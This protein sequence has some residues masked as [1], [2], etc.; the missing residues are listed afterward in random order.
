MKSYSI[1]FIVDTDNA[2][3]DRIFHQKGMA[4]NLDDVITQTYILYKQA[5]QYIWKNMESAIFMDIRP[6]TMFS[7]E[8]ML[9]NSCIK[10]ETVLQ[11]FFQ[12]RKEHWL[13]SVRHYERN[14][15]AL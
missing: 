11:L 10:E 2:E 6:N 4:E 12:I 1:N 3:R 9:G 7:I 15:A 8:C 5:T 14:M 13:K